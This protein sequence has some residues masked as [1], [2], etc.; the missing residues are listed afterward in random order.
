ME[1]KH[2]S[3]LERPWEYLISEIQWGVANDGIGDTF[4]DVT[5]IKGASVHRL[6]FIALRHTRLELSGAYP[7]DC[8]EMVILDIR[9]RGWEGLTVE[10][11]E[12]G[13]SGSP[14]TLYAREVIELGNM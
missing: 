6:R 14:L 10:V 1:Q 5:F 3:I 4:L 2:H 8:G 11:T 12:G 7:Q 9:D 13:A